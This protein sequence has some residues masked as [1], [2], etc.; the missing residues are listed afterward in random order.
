M[1][2]DE[3]IDMDS[4][5]DEETKE[6]SSSESQQSQDSPPG[7]RLRDLRPEKDPMGAGV[8]TPATKKKGSSKSAGND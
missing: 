8:K 5:N 3:R 7:S 4:Q 1:H 2:N 6:S